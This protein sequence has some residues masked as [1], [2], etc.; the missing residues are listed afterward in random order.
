MDPLMSAH[1]RCAACRLVGVAEVPATQ[2]RAQNRLLG[3]PTD[4]LSR[5]RTQFV[6]ER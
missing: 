1:C 3:L 5:L 4:A 2:S 6:F